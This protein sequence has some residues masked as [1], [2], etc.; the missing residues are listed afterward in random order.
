MAVVA[1]IGEWSNGMQSHAGITYSQA[2]EVLERFCS[3]LEAAPTVAHQMQIDEKTVAGVLYGT[4]W[5]QAR[6]FWLDNAV[7]VA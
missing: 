4:V 5:P 2:M 1:H 3:R 7:V 6:Q